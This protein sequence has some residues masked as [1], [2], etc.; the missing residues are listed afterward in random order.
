[1]GRELDLWD[2]LLLGPPLQDEADDILS[3]GGMVDPP[4]KPPQSAQT[5]ND[6]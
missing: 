2:I 3:V 1:M 6:W 5:P 4:A